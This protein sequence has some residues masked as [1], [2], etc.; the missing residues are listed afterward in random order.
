[1]NIAKKLREWSVFI[2][3]TSVI[4]F[5]VWRFEFNFK[6]YSRA[7]SKEQVYDVRRATEQLNLYKELYNPDDDIM[8]NDNDK[9]DTAKNSDINSNKDSN[10][11]KVRPNKLMSMASAEDKAKIKEAFDGYENLEDADEIKKEI[12]KIKKQIEM[13]EDR[14]TTHQ[15]IKLQRV[16]YG[17]EPS[18]EALKKIRQHY[19]ESK[20]ESKI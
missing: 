15:G 12:A 19:K 4:S 20:E 1:M 9:I 14:K 11:N 2:Y 18:E 17:Y 8:A 16:M 6:E 3:G 5:V 10:K 13:L 7:M